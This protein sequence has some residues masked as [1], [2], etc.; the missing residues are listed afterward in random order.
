MKSAN[1]CLAI[2]P[3]SGKIITN[4]LNKHSDPARV[5]R[6]KKIVRSFICSFVRS[7]VRLFLFLCVFYTSQH[8]C[9]FCFHLYCLVVY[10]FAFRTFY[11]SIVIVVHL[12][13][14]RVHFIF[15]NNSYR[16]INSIRHVSPASILIRHRREIKLTLLPAVL[17]YAG[18]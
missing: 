14:P 7:S 12:N 6:R 10:C 2:V 13:A 4:N 18:K 3:G 16:R 8:P 11:D 17:L 15:E 1:F 9:R 5:H